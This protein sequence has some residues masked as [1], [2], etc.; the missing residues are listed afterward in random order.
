MSVSSIPAVK[1]RQRD[2]A[3]F[4]G[5]SISTVSRALSDGDGVSVRL[6]EQVLEAADTLGYRPK[7]FRTEISHLGL[8][9]T[10]VKPGHS[11]DPFHA[12]ILS[13]VEAEC[14]RIGLHLS[15]TVVDPNID[16]SQLIVDKVRKNAIDGAL[17]LSVDNRKLIETLLGHGL[18]LTLINSDHT[19]LPVDSYLPDNWGGPLIATRYLIGKAHRRI[20]YASLLDRPTRRRRFQA[21]RYALEEAG[22]PFDGRLFV[23][24]PLFVDDAYKAMR[25]FL[26]GRKVDFSAVYCG[27]DLVAFGVIHALQEAGLDVPNDV[28]VIGLDD[29]PM[30]AYSQPPLTTTRLRPREVGIRAV[31]GALERE[32]RPDLA[33]VRVELATELVERASVKNLTH[34]TQKETP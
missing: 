6:R 31:M 23:E 3:T 26:A 8:F 7:L 15:Y 28:S 34:T 19:A 27:N 12:E 18:R 22:V 1:V 17:L 21:F 14:Q 10:M 11:L 33:P 20:V 5:V 29:N 13:G 30:A 16:S 25:T 24:T 2:I 4:M 9:T 32:K